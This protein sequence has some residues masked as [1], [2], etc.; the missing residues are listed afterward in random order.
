M[1]KFKFLVFSLVLCLFAFSSI[2]AFAEGE[3]IITGYTVGYS[4]DTD[5]ALLITNTHSP[6]K[7]SVT[8]KINF[9]DSGNQDNERPESLTATLY[10]GSTVV[11]TKTITVAD[12]NALDPDE[13]DAIFTD[14]YKYENGVIIPYTVTITPP[15]GYTATPD[16]NGLDTTLDN[17]VNT[18]PTKTVAVAFAD[19]G[20]RDAVRPDS[21][22]VQ[23]LQ[24]G[25]AYGDPVTLTTLASTHSFENLPENVS[26]SVGV[27]AVYTAEIVGT[28]NGYTSA[29]S[30]QLTDNMV[31][32]LTHTVDTRSVTVK[33]V[34]DDDGNRDGKRQTVYVQLYADGVASGSR[35]ELT[36]AN[37]VEGEDNKW[38]YTWTG[39]TLNSGETT[40]EGG[41]VAIVYSVAEFAA[42]E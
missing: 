32:T 16:D 37:V 15:T 28:V 27:T 39:L 36:A 42:A 3:E 40:A 1:H 35:I 9:S 29:L 31:L 12:A 22:S 30:G 4:T 5:G 20:D 26:G 10:N 13:W 33:K 38:A 17:P 41:P 8:G 6:E 24:N 2:A 7:I 18:I 34:W 14:L 11:E 25:V 19:D 23:L 21:V